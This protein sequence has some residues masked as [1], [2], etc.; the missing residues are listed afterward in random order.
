M[1]LYEFTCEN[2]HVINEFR[3]IKDET[4][5]IK[6]PFCGKVAKKIISNSN[7]VLKGG[8]WATSGYN[9]KE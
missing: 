8:G 9:K 2:N 4:N 7:F 5:E 1:P 3:S 6:C